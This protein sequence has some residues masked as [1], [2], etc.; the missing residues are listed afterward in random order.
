MTDCDEWSQQATDKFNGH[1]QHQD[2]PVHLQTTLCHYLLHMVLLIAG[3]TSSEMIQHK[4][5]DNSQQ[6]WHT[7]LHVTKLLAH[8]RFNSS[9]HLCVVK[10]QRVKT[11]TEMWI[12]LRGIPLYIFWDILPLWKSLR[13]ADTCERQMSQFW[14]NRYAVTYTVPDLSSTDLYKFVV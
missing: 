2:C 10:P 4:A 11:V 9:I 7:A 6:T 3:L 13:S 5:E 14:W 8:W 12:I 1:F